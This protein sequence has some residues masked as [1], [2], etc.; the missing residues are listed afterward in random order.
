MA[1]VRELQPSGVG[2]DVIRLIA[3]SAALASTASMAWPGWG[4]TSLGPCPAGY[5][6]GGLTPCR[7]SGY[8][9]FEFAPSSGAGLGSLCGCSTVTG[10]NG[11][12]LT[13]SRAGN[14]T[15]SLTNFDTPRVGDFLTCAAN[16]PRIMRN[17]KGTLGYFQEH[18]RTNLVLWSEDFSNV[19]WTTLAT[20][21]TDTDLSPD[22]SQDADTINDIDVGSNQTVCQLVT[23]TAQVQYAGSIYLKAKSLT[24]A[25]LSVV[26]VGNSAGDCAT[27]VQA[28]DGG[29]NKLS[30]L[31][32]AVYGAGKTGLMLCLSI[33]NAASDTGTIVAWGAQLVAF[34]VPGTDYIRIPDS[35]IK[36]TSAS[37]VRGTD[38]MTF[39]YSPASSNVMSVSAVFSVPSIPNTDGGIVQVA[40]NDAGSVAE[41]RQFTTGTMTATVGGT[42]STPTGLLSLGA[43]NR[44]SIYWD[45]AN[46]NSCS[47]SSCVSATSIN[48]L[49]GTPWTVWIGR[50]SS[51]LR[52]IEGIVSQVCLD[53]VSATR[54]Q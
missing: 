24:S 37:V 46:Q 27:G 28:L 19:A 50:E 7:P 53:N 51:S 45:G 43:V 54:C 10:A 6:G 31:S 38:S 23:S 40:G 4:N 14:A 8:A 13:F 9:G 25:S 21:T 36:T 16:F 26:G 12:A 20:V 41:L 42:S 33:G 5:V 2:I 47:N 17:A 34:T 35:Y 30:C 32:P 48:A 15:C 39:Q 44:A 29:Y 49:P 52:T 1:P 18:G 3:M 22:G 11:E